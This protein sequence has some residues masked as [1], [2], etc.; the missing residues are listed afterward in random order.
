MIGLVLPLLLAIPTTQFS[1]DRKRRSHKR[2]QTSSTPSCLLHLGS[3]NWP[4][5]K[6]KLKTMLM[7][8]FG[9]TNNEY[10]GMSSG[11]FCSGHAIGG[12]QTL[13]WATW[14]SYPLIFHLLFITSPKSGSMSGSSIRIILT[15]FDFSSLNLGIC[16]HEESIITFSRFSKSRHCR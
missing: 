16:Q 9:V 8:N 3:A 6:K 10:Y 4:L 7:Q 13:I 11:I 12:R 14:P 15:V 5:Q 1:F 2:N